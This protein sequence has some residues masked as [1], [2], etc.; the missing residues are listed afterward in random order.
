MAM[1]PVKLVKPATCVSVTV[2]YVQMV[3]GQEQAEA[4]PCNVS[5][6]NVR[7]LV[8]QNQIQTAL[9]WWSKDR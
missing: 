4:A 6:M 1:A 7:K 3:Q 2:E 8:A 5:R 9:D